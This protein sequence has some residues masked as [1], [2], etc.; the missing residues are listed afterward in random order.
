MK[1]I[2]TDVVIDHFTGKELILFELC[3]FVIPVWEGPMV[4]RFHYPI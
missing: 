4:R 2:D 3:D 1:L